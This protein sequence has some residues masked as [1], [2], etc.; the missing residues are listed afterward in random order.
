MWGQKAGEINQPT[1]W[2]PVIAFLIK[3]SN[4]PYIPI[5]SNTL[6]FFLQTLNIIHTPFRWE[7]CKDAVLTTHWIQDNHSLNSFMFGNHSASSYHG[8]S[9]I[10]VFHVCHPLHCYVWILSYRNSYMREKIVIIYFFHFL[11]R[12]LGQF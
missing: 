4:G 1:N 7:P 2:L 3:L 12:S 5:L 11:C 8:V 10:W 6:T 9:P